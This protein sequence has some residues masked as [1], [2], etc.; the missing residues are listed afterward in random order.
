MQART[1]A[2]LVRVLA[3]QTVELQRRIVVVAAEALAAGRMPPADIAD[4]IGPA[5]LLAA[6]RLVSR[7]AVRASVLRRLTAV[8]MRALHRVLAR[9]ERP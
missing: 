7:G 3:S 1:H 4:L 9:S 5:D 2:A 6:Y 8:A